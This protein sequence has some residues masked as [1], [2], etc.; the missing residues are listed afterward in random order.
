MK[1]DLNARELLK[2][3]AGMTLVEVMIAAGLLMFIALSVITLMSFSTDQ[4]KIS[5]KKSREIN[6]MIALTATLKGQS[7]PATTVAP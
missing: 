5:R 6:D 2:N 4:H 7:L 3:N 1:F